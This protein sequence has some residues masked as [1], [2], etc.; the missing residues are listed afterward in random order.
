[1]NTRDRK[2]LLPK[3]NKGKEKKL[4]AATLEK[5]QPEGVYFSRA[6]NGNITI[7]N[8]YTQ[9]T[10]Y[11]T[12]KENIDLSHV[13]LQIWVESFINSSRPS[14]LAEIEQ[15]KKDKRKNVKYMAGDIFTFKINR[16]EYSFGMVLLDVKKIRKKGLIKKSWITPT[17]GTFS[18]NKALR[19]NFGN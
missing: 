1:M 15:F 9:R 6:E 7:G 2:Y 3:T 19:I 12:L 11:S 5:H 13:T 17:Y 16:N 10:F 18:V 14:H 4:T 8:Y